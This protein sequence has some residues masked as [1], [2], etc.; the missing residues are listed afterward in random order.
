MLPTMGN[1]FTYGAGKLRQ[2]IRPGGHSHVGRALQF[3]AFFHHEHRRMDFAD[4]HGG[5]EEV[6]ALDRRDG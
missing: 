6:H 3:R 2:F 5:F 4:K 1:Q